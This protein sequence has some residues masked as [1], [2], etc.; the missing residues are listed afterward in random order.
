MAP[1]LDIDGKSL[2]GN[3]PDLG[4]APSLGTLYET[5]TERSRF[6]AFM[7]GGLAIAGVL[8]TFLVSGAGSLGAQGLSVHN[9]GFIRTETSVHTGQKAPASTQPTREILTH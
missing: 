7:I 8:L 4:S 9:S 1:G 6:V 3:I 5:S 2:Q